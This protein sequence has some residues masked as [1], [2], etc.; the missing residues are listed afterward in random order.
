MQIESTVC[1]KDREFGRS[2]G[3]QVADIAV[4]GVDIG[5][6]L[7]VDDTVSR[8][9]EN[10]V[11]AVAYEVERLA[12]G[13]IE[14]AVIDDQLNEIFPVIADNAGFSCQPQET[15]SVHFDVIDMGP[16]KTR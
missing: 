7:Q 5:E 6:I 13:A 1:I 3:Y 11:Q 16:V 8:T 14:G 4:L 10:A 12:I 9:R 15:L 2:G